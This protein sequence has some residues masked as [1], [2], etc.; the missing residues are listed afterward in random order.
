MLIAVVD[1][2]EDDGSPAGWSVWGGGE[3]ADIALE[4]WEWVERRFEPGEAVWDGDS[5]LGCDGFSVEG[6]F[7]GLAAGEEDAN[8]QE[9]GLAGGLVVDDFGGLA[10]A[11]LANGMA[12]EVEAAQDLVEAEGSAHCS[13]WKLREGEAWGD[14]AALEDEQA[15]FW[16]EFDQDGVASEF[17]GDGSG[18]A[19]TAERVEDGA[20]SNGMFV[21][22][23]V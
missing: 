5:W 12:V 13:M 20:G 8:V 22:R 9:V 11:D 19:A 23:Q 1:V 17:D 7:A 18:C 21:E 4:G 10:V 14:V 3:L 16:V 15:V 6:S 2:A